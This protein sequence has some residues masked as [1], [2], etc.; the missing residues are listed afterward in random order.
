MCDPRGCIRVLLQATVWILLS[1]SLAGDW[2]AVCVAD[3]GVSLDISASAVPHEQWA[4]LST[5]LVEYA[6]CRVQDSPGFARDNRLRRLAKIAYLISP[7]NRPAVLLHARLKKQL[8][9]PPPKAEVDSQALMDRLLETAHTAAGT[10]QT[11][12]TQ[13]ARF[14]FAVGLVVQ[15]RNEDCLFESELFINRQGPID[16]EPLLAEYVRPINAPDGFQQTING[17]AV[18]QINHQEVGRV[19]KILLTYREDRDKRKNQDTRIVFARNVGN[20][21]KVSLEEAVRYWQRYSTGLKA[22]PGI[23]EI[24]FED[25]YS[26]KDGGS[27]GAAYAV[28][29]HS[30]THQ[31]SID[32]KFA[33]TGDISVEGKVLQ[34]GGVFAKIRG[35]LLDGC[36]RVAIPQSNVEDLIDDVIIHGPDVL[37]QIEIFSLD[38]ID[39]AIEL[40]R[41]DKARRYTDATEVWTRLATLLDRDDWQD[42]AESKAMLGQVVELC[43]NH[44]SARLLSHLADGSLRRHLSLSQ[45]ILHLNEIFSQYIISISP[46]EQPNFLAIGEQ[47][48]TAH[49]DQTIAD[50]EAAQSRVD[51]KAETA[52]ED[53]L[54]TCE[55]IA[56]FTRANR[57]VEDQQKILE[58]KR[59]NI[60][61]SQQVLNRYKSQLRV[62]SRASVTR[63]NGQVNRVN[64][65]IRNF[66]NEQNRLNERIRQRNELMEELSQAYLDYYATVET[67]T[68]DQEILEKLIRGQ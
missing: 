3:S 64:K 33:M 42:S 59:D 47:T 53:L 30:F 46:G 57:Q 6:Q 9:I 39:D 36:A 41:K 48:S 31:F 1:L 37:K 27:A 63:Y 49:I 38:A 7:E 51:P 34:I 18:S 5:M 8:K 44:V 35:A 26:S 29:I 56:R 20:H 52:H 68:Q 15:P 54:T 28:L 10:G 61:R 11:A 55:K 4:T 58:R 45:S 13:A 60:E 19:S 21:M 40:A 16:W 25:K 17:L 2:G 23:I 65:A 32:E 67:L 66:K 22:Q 14:L 43:P 12:D 50:L 24:S 62:D